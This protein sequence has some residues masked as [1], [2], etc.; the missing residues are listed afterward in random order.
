MLNR[1]QPALRTRLISAKAPEDRGKKKNIL[2]GAVP[3]HACGEA[4]LREGALGWGHAY[5]YT[6]LISSVCAVFWVSIKNP[7]HLLGGT[8][9]ASRSECR[10]YI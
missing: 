2:V 7:S 6:S 9:A 8:K 3:G 4:V 5:K 10:A 1:Q